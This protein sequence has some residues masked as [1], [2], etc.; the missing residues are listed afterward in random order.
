MSIQLFPKQEPAEKAPRE[1]KLRKKKPRKGES[2]AQGGQDNAEQPPRKGGSLAVVQA[3]LPLLKPAL[4][5]IR[6]R[7]TVR[8]LKLHVVWAAADPADAAMGYGAANAALGILWPVFYQNFKIRDHALGIDVDFD[9]VEPTVYAE[10]DL[11][12]TVFQIL[13]LALPLFVRFYQNY[14]SDNAAP[15][16]E[17]VKKEAQKHG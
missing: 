1:K 12:M 13:T 4:E 17:T 6:K 16:G 8:R 5:G 2:P 14:R 9:A 10:A 7:L 3:C 15:T 11:K